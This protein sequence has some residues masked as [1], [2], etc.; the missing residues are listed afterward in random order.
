M[1]WLLGSILLIGLIGFASSGKSNSSTPEVTPNPDLLDDL[2]GEPYVPD[3]SEGSVTTQ[4]DKMR[5][6][7]QANAGDE[8]KTITAYAAAE[9]AGEVSRRSNDYAL[10]SEEYARRLLID[11]VR[12]GAG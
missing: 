4:R 12:K 7:F 5:E 8:G 6:L 9:R 1:I 10:N 2:D 3:R 11:G